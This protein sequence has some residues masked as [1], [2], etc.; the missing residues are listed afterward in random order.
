[1]FHDFMSAFSFAKT[2]W[3]IIIIVIMF[4]VL[5][6]KQWLKQFPSHNHC[7]IIFTH[8]YQRHVL[9]IYDCLI[10]IRKKN[11]R[12][13]ISLPWNFCRRF[14]K[15]RHDLSK[16]S[17]GTTFPFHLKFANPP[18]K[19]YIFTISNNLHEVIG[20]ITTAMLNAVTI[21]IVHCQIT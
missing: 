16:Y 10:K 5:N 9:L 7:H 12:K 3:L 14:D 17:P 18:L 8:I 4:T 1:M 6:L 21:W 2:H 20:N 11:Q 19:S 13:G 15:W